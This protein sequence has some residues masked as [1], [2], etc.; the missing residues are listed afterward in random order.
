MS[1]KKSYGPPPVAVA[2]SPAPPSDDGREGLASSDAILDELDPDVAYLL[3]SAAPD[4][5]PNPYA[6][7]QDGWIVGSQE[8]DPN[9]AVAGQGGLLAPY[10][11]QD[12]D[13][14]TNMSADGANPNAY[15]GGQNV[16]PFQDSSIPRP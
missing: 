6:S 16:D 11:G 15:T 14:Y 4:G 8:V 5:L 13:P 2:S 7:V 9:G 12:V 1:F 3:S 10:V